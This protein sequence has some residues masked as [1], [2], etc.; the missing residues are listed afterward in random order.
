[1]QGLTQNAI[2]ISYYCTALNTSAGVTFNV[3]IG[4]NSTSGFPSTGGAI[5]F[6]NSQAANGVSYLSARYND[7]LVARLHTL[8]A[9]EYSVATGTTTWSHTSNTFSVG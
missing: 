7:A 6:G 2:N 9:N 3:G 1:M 8:S 4:I 5:G